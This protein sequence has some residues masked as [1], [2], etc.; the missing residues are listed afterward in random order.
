MIDVVVDG[1]FVEEEK[2]LR[3]RFRGSRNQRLINIKETLHAN[4][5][6]EYT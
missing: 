5:I 4:K 2:D 3:I 6:I 1:P